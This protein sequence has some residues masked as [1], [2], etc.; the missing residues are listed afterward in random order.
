M[1]HDGAPVPV[2][3]P[4][5]EAELLEQE[6]IERSE[7]LDLTGEERK[8]VTQ[9]YDFSVSSLVDDIDGQRLLLRMEYQRS[10]VWDD[11]KATRLI[12]SLLLNVPIPVCY[13]AENE[14]GT[15]EVV[16]GQQRLHSIWRFVSPQAGESQLTL[17]GATVLNEINGQSFSQ[18]SQRDQ[19][20]TLNRTIRCIVITEDSHPD[21]KFDVFERLN[22][23]AVRLTDQELRNS[24]YRGALNDRLKD[25][26]RYEP[27][28]R[29][30]AGQLVARM[31]D[32]ELVLRFA[33]LADRLTSY[34]PPLRQFLSEYMRQHRADAVPVEPL[35]AAF[36]Q[37][38][39]TAETLF[40]EDAFRR[41][42]RAGGAGR[43]VNKALF[44]TV[45]LSL[46]LA[47]QTAVLAQKDQVLSEFRSL[48]EEP[49][50][51]VLIGR[52]T[53][54]RARVFGRISAFSERLEKLGIPTRYR[55]AIP[56]A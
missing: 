56:Q 6:E 52:A 22:T 10:Y 17:R 37:A 42:N 27:F 44:D 54:D 30:L 55:Q 25:V 49:D 9:P 3:D 16:D 40:G 13:F 11:A 51:D 34:K 14:D 19:R 41:V 36:Q 26:A 53:A 24:I 50:F 12:E 29:A 38:A 7:P 8:L 43:T 46:H 20:R 23:G 1:A 18:L 28:Q 32:V 5:I 39:T 35:L 48:L 33:A 31:D 4:A 21:I 47:D 2:V 15:L 45:M